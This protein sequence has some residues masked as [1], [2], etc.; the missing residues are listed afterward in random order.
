MRAANFILAND[1]KDPPCTV[2]ALIDHIQL[3]EGEK[4]EKLYKRCLKKEICKQSSNRY[5]N[6]V[7]VKMKR[8]EGVLYLLYLMKNEDNLKYEF[9]HDE[10]FPS[11]INDEF[12]LRSVEKTVNYLDQ[13]FSTAI[14]FLFVDEPI[15]ATS[16]SLE[17]IVSPTIVLQKLKNL[18]LRSF[19]HYE[20]FPTAGEEVQLANSIVKYN[21]ELQ[22][23]EQTIETCSLSQT[24]DVILMLYSK[25]RRILNPEQTKA[26]CDIIL[27]YVKGPVILSH[28]LDPKK[29]RFWDLVK[30][31]E[32]GSYYYDL[33]GV[34][35]RV[36]ERQTVKVKNFSND[37]GCYYDKQRPFNKISYSTTE[38]IDFW[39][40]ANIRD[41]HSVLAGYARG[42]VGLP[43]KTPEIDV[44]TFEKTLNHCQDN[45]VTRQLYKILK[46]QDLL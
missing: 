4:L 32:E 34:K 10:K 41:K 16:E 15:I 21:E 24:M 22:N 35:F 40:N 3:L 14:H 30:Q 19:V 13:K 23:L 37:I 33:E 20:D 2:K 25:V 43:S 9:G 46:V 7:V 44:K 28:V 11:D 39:R 1:I 18:R 38:A 27:E 36:V 42:I 26:I 5:L 17:I 45:D 8:E 12:L 31:A 29:K 6:M